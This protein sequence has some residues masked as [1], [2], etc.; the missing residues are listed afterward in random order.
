MN[1]HGER[2]FMKQR[3][4]EKKNAESSG[5]GNHSREGDR[6]SELDMNMELIR[7]NAGEMRGLT[8]P[9]R[10]RIGLHSWRRWPSHSIYV[11]KED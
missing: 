8:C 6:Q 5:D 10:A 11:Q 3:E 9:K 1:V 7:M 4:T 2:R